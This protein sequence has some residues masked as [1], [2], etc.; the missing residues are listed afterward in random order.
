MTRIGIILLL[1]FVSPV[2]AGP[3]I[4]AG[5]LALRHDIQRLADSGVVTGTITTWGSK[6]F[7][8]WMARV[9]PMIA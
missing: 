9:T 7:H 3:D 5:D 2:L 6:A 1:L 4:P 8:A